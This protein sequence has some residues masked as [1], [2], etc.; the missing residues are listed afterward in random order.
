MDFDDV[1]DAI[2]ADFDGD[3]GKGVADA[4]EIVQVDGAGED[5]VFVVENGADELGGRAGDTE[6]RAALSVVFKVAAAVDFFEDVRV[7]VHFVFPRIFGEE[8][9]DLFSG[10]EDVAPG[11]HAA[12]AVFAQEVGG[13]GAAIHAELH[14]EL[15]LEAGG[16]EG[17]AGAD[18]AVFRP[19]EKMLKVFGDDVARIGNGNND[20]VESGFGDEWRELFRRFHGFV[21]HVEARLLGAAR[22]AGGIDDDVGVA[23]IIH[24]AAVAGDMVRHIAD[25][26]HDVHGFGRRFF[27]FD[28]VENNFIRQTLDGKVQSDVRTDIARADDSDF[29]GFDGHEKEVLSIGM[30]YRGNRGGTVS[31]EKLEISSS[32]GGLRPH[33]YNARSAYPY[34]SPPIASYSLPSGGVSK[35]VTSG[36]RW[37]SQPA[38]Q[39]FGRR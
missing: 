37:M 6:F 15:H 24:G 20:A 10:D 3:G 25:G 7:A 31:S 17:R 8:F 13:D 12:V 33:F 34:C 35:K 32:G 26:V 2:G 38:C 21:H 11:D 19:I 9:I 36:L 14:G 39:A 23:H 18:D 29:S 16:V 4:V 28:V 27:L 1:F 5:F 22:L 30:K